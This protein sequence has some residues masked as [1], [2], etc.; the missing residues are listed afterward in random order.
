M[1]NVDFKSMGQR[2]KF[3]KGAS[4]S[5]SS[6]SICCPGN[7]IP[8]WFEFQSNGFSINLK[9][10]PQWLSTTFLGFA[11]CI[12]AKVWEHKRGQALKFRCESHLKSDDGD[13]VKFNGSMEVWY[14]RSGFR[15]SQHDHMFMLYDPGLCFDV[16]KEKKSVQSIRFQNVTKVSFN[17]YVVGFNGE[18]LPLCNVKRCGISLVYAQDAEVLCAIDKNVGEPSS[19][20]E[21]ATPN[22]RPNHSRGWK[23]EFLRNY[24]QKNK[25]DKKAVLRRVVVVIPM[26]LILSIFFVTGPYGD[27]LK[28][29]SKM[30]AFVLEHYIVSSVVFIFASVVILFI[31]KNK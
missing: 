27:K 23:F 30:H 31:L 2:Y 26:C 1:N 12:V 4:A 13:S 14:R 3:V 6:V 9:L 17:F 11:V 15:F 5:F 28:K 21:G 19:S 8:E 16:N 20:K 18:C 25:E 29:N 10:P 22:P 24:H 7:K